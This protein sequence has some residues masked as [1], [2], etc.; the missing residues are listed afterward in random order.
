[1][2]I[3]WNIRLDGYVFICGRPALWCKYSLVDIVHGSCHLIYSV[4]QLMFW[5][6]DDLSENIIL[7]VEFVL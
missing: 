1:M 5:K 7:S 2:T 3:V 4:W 6:L